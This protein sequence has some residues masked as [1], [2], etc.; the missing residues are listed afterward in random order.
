MFDFKQKYVLENERALLSPLELSHKE[1]L[2]LQSNDETIWTHFTEKGF[3]KGNFEHYFQNALLQQERGEQ[4]CFAIQDR[5]S[6]EIAGMTRVYN[7]NNL[8]GNCKIG[9]TWLGKRFQGSGLNKNCKYLLF[10]FLFDQLG[11]KRIGFGASAENIKSI[12]A[13]ESV[14]C[15]QEGKL[16]SFLPGDSGARIDVVLL[17][18]LNEEWK[19]HIK[20]ALSKRLSF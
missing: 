8:F 2:F 15:K 16:R 13:M 6:N 20:H 17:S 4:Y 9:H 5:K 1:T 18:L 19:S 7:V 14:G 3:G 11:M 10:E 12:K